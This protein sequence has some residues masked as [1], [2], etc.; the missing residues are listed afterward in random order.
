ML[1]KISGF[2]FAFILGIIIFSSISS[3]RLLFAVDVVS[4][5]IFSQNTISIQVITNDNSVKVG[6]YDLSNKLVTSEITTN[7]TGTFFTSPVDISQLTN[8]INYVIKITDK[9]NILDKNPRTIIFKKLDS[10]SSSTALLTLD[11][12]VTDN[13][14]FK[15]SGFPKNKTVIFSVEQFQYNN[16][17]QPSSVYS[18][19]KDATTSNNG[20]AEMSFVLVPGGYYA[21]SV[22]MKDKTGEQGTLFKAINYTVPINSSAKITT[23]SPTSGKVGDM[24]TITGNNFIGVN[25]ILFGTTKAVTITNTPTQISVKVPTGATSGKIKIET[26]SYG[27]ATSA[28]DF[29]V[30]GNSAISNTTITNNESKTISDD[31]LCANVSKK[32]E[33]KG[34]VPVCNT[35]VDSKGGYCNPCNFNSLLGGVNKFINFVLITLA[36]PL[37]ALILIYVG[38]LYLSAGGSSENVTKAKKILKNALIGY[39]IALAAWLIV[40]TILTALNFTGPMFLG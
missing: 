36:T 38:W 8:G 21:I 18:E 40:K 32:V 26:T 2:I 1:K 24:I 10:Q 25:N 20:D 6:V 7:K 16:S 34:L 19:S 39:I 4:D 15:A 17:S 30:I 3:P 35:I 5:V 22:Q 11:K 28:S 9:T 33:F 12:I 37:F 14:F 27:N 31:P 29:T 23:V 13:T